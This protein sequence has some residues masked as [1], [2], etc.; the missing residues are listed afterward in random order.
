MPGL[1]FDKTMPL[2]MDKSKFEK[3]LQFRRKLLHLRGVLWDEVSDSK[4]KSNLQQEEHNSYPLEYISF[5]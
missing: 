4:A 2:F 3:E 1:N 5:V